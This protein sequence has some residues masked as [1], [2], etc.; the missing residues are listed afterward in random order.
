MKFLLDE[1]ADFPLATFLRELGHDVTAIAHDYP[2]ALKDR[3][4]LEIAVREQRILIT[5]DHDFGE[6]VFRQ[7]LPHSGIIL[8]RLRAEDLSTKRARLEQVITNYAD[9]LDRF[10]VLTDGGVRVRQNK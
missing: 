9:K 6:L 5:N 1:S 8:F 2:H 10:L 3:Q 7:Q 4:V